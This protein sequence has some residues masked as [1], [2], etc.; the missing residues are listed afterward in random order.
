MIV[1]QLR[2]SGTLALLTHFYGFTWET[3][4]RSTVADINAL[5]KALPTRKE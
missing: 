3:V 1:R 2:S 4:Y 5:I